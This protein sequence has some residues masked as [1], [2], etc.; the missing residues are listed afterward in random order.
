MGITYKKKVIPF[1]F[2]ISNLYYK[3]IKK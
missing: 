1:L 2:E 3:N